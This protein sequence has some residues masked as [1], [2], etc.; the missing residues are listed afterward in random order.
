[1]RHALNITTR[2]AAAI[3]AIVLLVFGFMGF[4]VAAVFH[5]D[6]PV[7]F[8]ISQYATTSAPLFFAWLSTG[9]WGLGAMV[10]AVR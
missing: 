2:T 9:M 3:A 1:M 10:F 6:F 5:L 7:V 4:T 8:Q